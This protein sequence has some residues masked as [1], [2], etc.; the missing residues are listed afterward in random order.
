MTEYR[1]P[2]KK[3]I[4]YLRVKSIQPDPN[5][6]GAVAFLRSYANEIGVDS[7]KE[8]EVLPGR[9]VVLMTY[10]GE[11]PDLPSVLLNSHTDVVPVDQ[12]RWKCDAF[13]GFMDTNGDIYG[14]GVQD[15]KSVG[16]Q[17]LEV[18]R[19]MKLANVRPKRTIHLSFVPDE[20][21]GG[22]TG[23][24]P[25]LKTEEFKSLNVGVAFDEGQASPTE[26]FCVYYGERIVWWITITCTGNTGHGSRFIENTAAEKLQKVMNFI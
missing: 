1:T 16:V 2:T 20:E 4:E 15:M 5:Y 18:V 17:H 25:F 23:I 9:V 26:E 21:I 24:V 12:K 14:R 11:C 10:L 22:Q 6:A 13:E 3:L 7:C 8:V 19:K